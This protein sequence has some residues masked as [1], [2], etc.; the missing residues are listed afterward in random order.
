MFST[1]AEAA[2]DM[3]KVNGDSIYPILNM[4]NTRYVIMPLQGG[5]TVPV[6]NPYAYGNAWFVDKVL[7]VDNANQELDTT[8]KISLRHEAVAD[9]KFQEVL[10]ESVVQDEV[11]VV[12]LSSYEPNELKYETSSG[13]GG[14]VVFSEIYY[15]G[16]TATIDG[17]V[18]KL[19]RADYVLRALKVPAG[20]HQIVLTFKPKS[21]HTTETIAYVAGII[22]L[23]ALLAVCYVEY[24]KRKKA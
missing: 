21:I 3:T 9:K 7:Y 8:G 22:L 1:I 24:K 16:W 14:I 20:K 5:E 17:N 4:L 15:P 10:G 11:S 18:A 19:G 13:K 6:K 23:L 2:G 12:T